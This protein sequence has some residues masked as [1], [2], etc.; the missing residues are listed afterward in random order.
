MNYSVSFDG[1]V[2]RLDYTGDVSNDDIKDAHRELS[3]YDQ[4]YHCRSL[5]INL[6]KCSLKHVDVPRLLPVV[7]TDLGASRSVIKLKVAFI[8]EC[9][10]NM[11]RTSEYINKSH[12]LS[13]WEWRHFYCEE[14]AQEWFAES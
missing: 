2:A 1:N 13:P 6:L 3:S 9:T 8:V 11:E 4:F 7:A 12:K 10:V 14:N 5:I